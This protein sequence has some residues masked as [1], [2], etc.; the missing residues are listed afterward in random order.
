MIN[1]QREEAYFGSWFWKPP[2]TGAGPVVWACEEAACRDGSKSGSE[3][4]CFVVGWGA[5]RW[6]GAGVPEPRRHGWTPRDLKASQDHQ[7]GRACS[8]WACGASEGETETGAPL[9]LGVGRGPPQHCPWCWRCS[10]PVGPEQEVVDMESKATRGSDRAT[11]GKKSR[12]R[13][14][15]RTLLSSPLFASLFSFVQGCCSLSKSTKS[16]GLGGTE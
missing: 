5:E 7:A 9:L 1:S 8:T 15:G 10:G 2:S 13:C 12:R 16:T 14:C 4:T 6:G 11:H 3:T